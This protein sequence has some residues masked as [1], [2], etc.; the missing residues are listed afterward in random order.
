MDPK[1]IRSVI[2]CIL[3]SG[4]R[5]AKSKRLKVPLAFEWHQKNYLG[6]AHGVCGI[7]TILLQD[8]VGYLFGFLIFC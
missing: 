1:L 7:L 5:L 6:A 3:E 8:E 4:Q 2:S